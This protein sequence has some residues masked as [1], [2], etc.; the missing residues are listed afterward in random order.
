MLAAIA[1]ALP[2]DDVRVAAVRIAAATHEAAALE[3]LSAQSYAGA[4]WLGTYG[5]YYLTRRGLS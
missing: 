3:A 4:H 2:R 1:R 5:V